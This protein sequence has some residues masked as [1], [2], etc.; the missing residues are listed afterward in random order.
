MNAT[1]CSCCS[2]TPLVW[3]PDRLL[4]V[5]LLSAVIVARDQLFKT[6]EPKAEEWGDDSQWNNNASPFI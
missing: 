4:M 5:L 1:V 2:N 3:G 6:S